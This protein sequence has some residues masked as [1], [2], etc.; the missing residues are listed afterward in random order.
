MVDVKFTSLANS[1]IFGISRKQHVTVPGWH[2]VGVEEGEDDVG[3]AEGKND[4][5][6]NVGTVDGET[7]GDNDGTE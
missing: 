6:D 3:L 2:T 5:A 1:W 7:D 4:G